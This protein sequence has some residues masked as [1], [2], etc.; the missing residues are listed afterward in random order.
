M[1]W[2]IEARLI[3]DVSASPFTSGAQ[4]RLWLAPHLR[5][6]VTT[7]MRLEADCPYRTQVA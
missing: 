5:H 2:V 3:D 6:R 7:P 4:R 1:K